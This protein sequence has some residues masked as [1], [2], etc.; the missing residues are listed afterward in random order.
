VSDCLFCKII[1]GEIPST[2]IYE[3]EKVI[4]FKD[5]SPQSPVHFLVIP[6]EH[7]ES[8]DFIDKDKVPLIGH[9][10][11]VA[12]KIAKEQG[13]ECGYRVVNNCGDHGGQT[14]NHIHFHVLGGR[15]MMWPPG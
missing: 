1:N 11:Y 9:I 5:I 2:L 15:Q 10:F 3:D 12:S 4:A 14:V 7:I 6:K 8:A 13:L